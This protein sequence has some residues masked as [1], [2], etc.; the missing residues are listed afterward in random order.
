MEDIEPLVPVIIWL[1]MV[2]HRD[3]ESDEEAGWT[4]Q[5]LSSRQ[6]ERVGGAYTLGHASG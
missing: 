6:L 4:L 5:D 3:S 1:L 2:H